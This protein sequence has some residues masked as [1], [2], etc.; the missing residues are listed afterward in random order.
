MHNDSMHNEPYQT[1]NGQPH[2]RKSNQAVQNQDIFRPLSGA[3]L[4]DWL[5]RAKDGCLKLFVA[6][7]YRVH[8]STNGYFGYARIPWFKVGVVGFAAYV[9]L[10]KDFQF[11][12]NMGDPNVTAD[13]FQAGELVQPADEFGM[14]RTVS[15]VSTS[16]ADDRY[17]Q[18]SDFEEQHVNAY[19]RR[20]QDV[21]RSEMNKYRIPASV[22]MA[23]AILESHADQHELTRTTNN[24]FGAPLR[25][26]RYHSA[27]ENWRSHSL[28]L[29]GHP[30]K[31]LQRFELDYHAWAKALQEMGYSDDPQYA[32]K[33]AQLIEK[34]NL[35]YLDRK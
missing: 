8:H 19:I 10:F 2:G 28:F 9:A 31:D 23:Q 1:K 30:Y 17:P 15:L 24:H 20:F 29:Q 11:Q 35:T 7:K 25:G 27:W 18:V 32:R 6:F 33:L 16:T 5:D 12:I 21:A 13:Q 34:Y 4:L 14:V 3:D 26:Q 22:K